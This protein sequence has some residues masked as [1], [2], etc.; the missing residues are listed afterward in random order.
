MS[1]TQPCIPGGVNESL[2]GGRAMPGEMVSLPLSIDCEVPHWLP[3]LDSPQ[4][5]FEFL[6]SFGNERC[7]HAPTDLPPTPG[8]LAVRAAR[9]L[10]PRR[11]SAPSDLDGAS[12]SA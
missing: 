4:L 12:S 9:Q 10:H 1:S 5:G 8:L 3:Y 7:S 6:A 2:L 11:G